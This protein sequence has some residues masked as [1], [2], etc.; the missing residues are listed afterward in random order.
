MSLKM[1]RMQRSIIQNFVKDTQGCF[2]ETL[3]EVQTF[4]TTGGEHWL[5]WQSC[6]HLVIVNGLLLHADNVS[7]EK[8]R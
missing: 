8:Q 7:A 5:K 2:H 6:F 3:V 1:C 4:T